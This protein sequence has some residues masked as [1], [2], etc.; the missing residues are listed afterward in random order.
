MLLQLRE[1]PP[2]RLAYLR[3][4]GPYGHPALTDL[5]DRLAAWVHRH[6]GT[7]TSRKF[8]G[9]SHDNPQHIPPELCRYDACVEVAADFV[10][11]EDIAVQDFAGG[12]YACLRFVGTGPEVGAACQ[13]LY[14]QELPA[15]GLT[16]IDAP[17]LEIY[18]EDFAVDPVTH[19][20]AC[21]LCAGVSPPA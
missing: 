11:N 21:W 16:A 2:L 4:T 17:L 12:H 3:H 18:E 10:P 13:S 1:I 15:N 7:C 14:E 9:L 5:W 19:R 20:F 8:Y 6:P